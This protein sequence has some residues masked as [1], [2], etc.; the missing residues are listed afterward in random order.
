MWH[1]LQPGP[2]SPV[3]A[4]PKALFVDG[5]AFSSERS[6]KKNLLSRQKALTAFWE[7]LFSKRTNSWCAMWQLRQ[8]RRSWY[9]YR[10]PDSVLYRILL[11]FFVGDHF[12][13]LLDVIGLHWSWWDF[14]RTLETCSTRCFPMPQSAEI[15]G[16]RLTA[17]WQVTC[18]TLSS[19]SWPNLHSGLDTGHWPQQMFVQKLSLANSLVWEPTSWLLTIE[20]RF[21]HRILPTNVFTEP[22]CLL[23]DT[24]AVMTIICSWYRAVLTVSLYLHKP[25][26]QKAKDLYEPYGIC[27]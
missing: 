10:V 23:F 18:V 8:M 25:I 6:V 11:I 21:L 17:H 26:V 24:V 7:L 14:P 2:G 22:L 20:R 12:A 1:F 16:R 4:A 13:E 15:H 5:A 3:T 27:A 9:P 19:S